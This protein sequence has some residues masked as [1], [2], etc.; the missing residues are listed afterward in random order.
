MTGSIGGRPWLERTWTGQ[1]LTPDC[2]KVFL[3]AE[4]GL[5][6]NASIVA[7]KAIQGI[8]APKCLDSLGWAFPSTLQDKWNTP[9]YPQWQPAVTQLVTPPQ[10]ANSQQVCRRFN[11]GNCKAG[12]RCK[13]IH[14]C[15]DPIR[16]W[17]PFTS[18]AL[19]SFPRDITRGSGG[20]SQTFLSPM[21]RASMM[22][23]EALFA[24]CR[25]SQSMM[26]P[27]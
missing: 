24:H 25:I 14:T 5:F 2:T 15:S 27:R 4:P 17:L 23:L 3:L 9:P 19:G 13:Y 10:A 22:G 12:Q 20:S 7:T 26:W 16:P 18:I 11:K 21:A 1:P 6:N 8:S